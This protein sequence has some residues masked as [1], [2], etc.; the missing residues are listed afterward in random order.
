MA[1]AVGCYSVGTSEDLNTYFRAIFTLGAPFIFEGMTAKSL[2][3]IGS[4]VKKGFLKCGK[5]YKD[6]I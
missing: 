6:F 2:E 4:A 1:D 3:E 5:I